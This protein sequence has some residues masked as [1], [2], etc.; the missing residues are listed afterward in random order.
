MDLL[1][2]IKQQR[3]KQ[4]EKQPFEKDVFNPVSAIV[5][6]YGLEQ[7]FLD[8]FDNGDAYLPGESLASHRV[9][10]KAPLE[11]PL[12]SLVTEDEYTLAMSIIRRVDN[13]PYLKFA[14]TPE[15]IILCTPLYR[16]NPKLHPEKLT[17]YHFETL[18]MHE[19]AKADIKKTTIK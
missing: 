13:N 12:F 7:N 1:K 14:A 17:R 18:I 3:A 9:K 15:E 5:K 2:N 8:G 19:R 10:V 11:I 4:R 16:L 6:Q